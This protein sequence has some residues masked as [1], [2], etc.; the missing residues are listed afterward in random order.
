MPP[1]AG[2][3]AVAEDREPVSAVP[4][5]V[6][7]LEAAASPALAGVHRDPELQAAYPR[8]TAN[9][10]A[11]RL[12]ADGPVPVLAACR[13]LLPTTAP[14][15][16]LVEPEESRLVAVVPAEPPPHPRVLWAVRAEGAIAVHPERPVPV[17]ARVLDS[18]GAHVDG[19]VP[20]ERLGGRPEN[21]LTRRS[22][23]AAVAVV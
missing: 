23:L 22:L 6:E 20:A 5:V 1:T 17:V 4:C 15:N 8:V 11:T 7:G 12:T 14:P 10:A 2:I 13:V 18:P 16:G 9:A 3:A 19:S 21:G